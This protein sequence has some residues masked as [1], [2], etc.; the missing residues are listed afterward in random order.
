MK[1]GDKVLLINDDFSQSRSNPIDDHA[2]SMIREFPKLLNIYTVMY[3]RK[4]TDSLL[5]CEIR[6][7]I[8]INGKGQKLEEIHWR[9]WR[10]IKFN[11]PKVKQKK[12]KKQLLQLDLFEPFPELEL[13]Q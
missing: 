9:A 11:F 10:F 12:E 5:L 4:E 1:R 8:L 7:P 2:F 6:N 13:T 3:Y